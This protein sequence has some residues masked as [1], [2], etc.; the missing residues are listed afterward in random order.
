MPVE[1]KIGLP[2][3]FVYFKSSSS[4]KEADAIFNDRL[5]QLKSINKD[6]D[7]QLNLF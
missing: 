2:F 5:L 4:V 7:K 1:S 6:K 3:D